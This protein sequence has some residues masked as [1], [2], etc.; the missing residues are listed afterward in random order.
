[1]LL[2]PLFRKVKV[3]YHMDVDFAV[4]GQLTYGQRAVE[5]GLTPTGGGGHGRPFPSPPPPH[6]WPAVTG[7]V[8]GFP[9]APQHMSFQ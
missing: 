2:N 9:E 1:M 5:N 3:L 4:M 6:F 7:A 8:W